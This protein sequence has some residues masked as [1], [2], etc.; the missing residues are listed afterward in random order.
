MWLVSGA[1]LIAF[2]SYVALPFGLAW[3]LPRYAAQHGIHLD[4]GRVRV[5]PFGARL[6][7]SG[8]RVATSGDSSIEWS[9]VETRVDLAE[10]AA[11]RLVLDRFHLSEAK[12][13]A[14]DAGVDGV[15]VLPEIPAGLP[16]EV[17]VGELVIDD[18]ELATVSEALGHPATV[19]WLRISSLDGVF[20]PEGAEVEAALSIGTGRTRLHGRLNL[21]DTGWI[22]NASEIVANDVPLDGLPTVLGADGRWRGRLDG[23]GPVRLV[24]SPINGAFSATTGGRWAIEGLELGLAQITVSGARADWNGAA[25]MTSSGDAVNALSVDGDIGVREL[26]IEVGDLLDIEAAELMVQ[27]DAS[28]A[29]E[30]RLSMQGHAPAI[31]FRGKGGAFEAVDATA[32]N[33]VSQL[34]LTLADDVGVEVD[35]LKSGALTVNLPAARSIDIG[36]IELDRVVVESDSNAVVA[37]A[38][39]AERVDWRG[40]TGPRGTGTATRLAMRRIA[41][42]G[43]G[44][45]RV[46]STSAEAV[47]DRTGDSVLRLRE[48]A[49][50]ATSL[51]PDGTLAVGGVLVSDVWLAGETGT[52]VIERVTLDAVERTGGGAIRIAS[53]RAQLVDHART[54]DRAIVGTGLELAGGAVSGRAWEAKHVRLG[55]IAIETGDASY[56]MRELS[57][58][59]ATGE[60][61]RADARLATLGTLELGVGGHRAVI[62]DLAADAPRWQ[63]G[64]GGARAIEAASIALD[65]V[66][67]HRWRSSGWRLTGVETSASGRAT[68]DAASLESLVLNAS[69]DSTAGAQRIELDAPVFDGESAVHAASAF[70]ERAYFRTG[71]GFDIDVAGLRADAIDWN[72]D[73]LDA[74]R[75]AALLMSV[76]AAPVRAS[77]DTV[78]FSSARLGADGLHGLGTL[79]SASGRGRVEHVLE[80]S[81][82]AVALGGYRAPAYGETTFDFVET[83]DVELVGEGNQASLR[84]ERGAARDTRI[85][86]SGAT[87]IETAE[88]DGIVLAGGGTHARAS[89]R[90]LRASPLTLRESGLE[91]GAL[92]FAGIEGEIG[93]SASGDWE[94]PPVPIGTRDDRS[95]FRV[96]IREASTAEPGSVMRFTDRTTEPVFTES[97]DIASAELR[98]FDS[99]AIGVPA[100][101]SVD[102]TTGALKALH[103]DGVVVPTL[104]G[105]DFGL[106]ATV[107]ELSLRALSPYSRLHLGRSVEGGYADLTIDAR[108]RTSDLEAVADFTLSDV[109]L[110]KPGLAA[111]S[112][113]LDADD[114]ASLDA[115]LGSLADEQGR[116]ELAVPLRGWL[117]APGFDF[118]RLVIRALVRAVLENA[119]V[120]PESE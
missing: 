32:T 38:G 46:A 42:H 31:R 120:L 99:G 36:Q 9:N 117:D 43:D 113:G 118:D 72:D 107:H 22:L 101:F 64:A 91:I 12:L 16:Q 53:G 84:F 78:S 29:P 69:A 35:R 50:D 115:A 92:G 98:A 39:T 65:T 7:F 54:G 119:Q 97:V 85:D 40:F 4:V 112:S 13:H 27:V 114:S 108:I 3:Y 19:D 66:G 6:N 70:A 86:A 20:R 88:V 83:R 116:I 55:E 8:V 60:G 49:L 96:R 63:E 109:A 61:E 51:S 48:V 106:D 82:G 79:T 89:A 90:A 71:D 100:R 81:A 105:T 24:Y 93:L 30:P 44:E 94:L 17:S 18:I 14:G 5:D 34:A 56:A 11:G 2:A 74:E 10:L 33:L 52:L 77:F 104:T 47:E 58:A 45:F 103:A 21:D 111:G 37:A 102:A 59:D 68:A 57:L 25:F 67:R 87:V 95:S 62:E 75:G 28:Q 23:T 110:G 76:A 80:W 41:R 15:G 1:L 26:R 73:T